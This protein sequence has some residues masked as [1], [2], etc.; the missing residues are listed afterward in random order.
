MATEIMRLAVGLAIL[1]F[2]RQLSDFVLEHER[3]L[4]MVC[5]ERG[6]PLPAALTTEGSRTLYFCLGTFVALFQ[7]ARIWL[8]L[9]S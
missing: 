2:H 7:A 8:A 9:G 6:V 1:I 4:V 3:R 5:R